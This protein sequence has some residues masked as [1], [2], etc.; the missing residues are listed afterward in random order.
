MIASLPMYDLPEVR[1]ATDGW[2][3]G[4][5]RSLRRAGI[6][7][8]PEAL[9]RDMAMDEVWR[10][11]H[12]LLSQTCGYPLTHAYDG[13][14]EPVAT[15]AYAATGCEGA[16][17]C[18]LIVV[19]DDH[20]AG[21]LADL[22]G[23]VCAINARHSQSGYSALRAALSPL[24][25]GREFFSQVLES[26][27]HGNSMKMVGA[28]EADVCAVD[29]VTHALLER[30]QP[31]LSAGTRVLTT[32]ERAPGLPYVTR[33]GADRDL[34]NRLREGLRQAFDDPALED[35]RAAL[36][37]DGMEVLGIDDYEPI[38]AM[39]RSAEQ[40]GYPDIR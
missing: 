7:S 11:E 17:Y 28:G 32:T 22:E 36:L 31:E 26:G 3:S 18:S 4:V 9:T 5:A 8:V 10:S 29:C 12:L 2:W 40:A 38:V 21:V 20:P 15:P 30:Y 37:L 23:G 6:P 16:R 35:V 39:E 25:G 27:G 19:R 1:A 14:L 13:V 34:L 33:G 24:A